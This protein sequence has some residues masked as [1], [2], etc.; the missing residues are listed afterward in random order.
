MLRFIILLFWLGW[1]SAHLLSLWGAIHG[2]FIPGIASDGALL[3]FEFD[4][5]IVAVFFAARFLGFKK[6]KS[7]CISIFGLSVIGT[8]LLYSPGYSFWFSN[9][10][11]NVESLPEMHIHIMQGNTEGKG[12]PSGWDDDIIIL[13]EL[14][15][16]PLKAPQNFKLAIGPT[17]EVND[18]AI[19]SKFDVQ[20]SGLIKSDVSNWHQAAW[21]ILTTQ[22]GPLMVISVHTRSPSN[23]QWEKDRNIFF[24][25]LADFLSK[26]KKS[27]PII[28]SGD[29]N[30]T[31]NNREFKRLL[32]K[33][34]FN[35]EPNPWYPTWH[36]DVARFGIGFRID[37][38]L[39]LN[40][41]TIEKWR[42]LPQGLSDHLFSRSELLIK[43]R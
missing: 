4:A 38:T 39:G 2:G 22:K 8:F 26:Q 37:R 1:G 29:F 30:A 35:Q 13:S 15:S 20:K 10:D 41:V 31:P 6:N 34:D 7:L 27:M 28:I 16:G 19:Y 14:W 5:L 43:W 3:L 12:N 32:S 25:N 23:E 21:A 33:M 18:T 9:F 36:S 40:G 42:A 24:V 11:H 17:P